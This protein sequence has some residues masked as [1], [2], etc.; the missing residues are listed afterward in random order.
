MRP[1]LTVLFAD[2]DLL[3]V[4]KPA[5]LLSVPGRGPDKQDCAVSRA[6][7]RFGEI[8]VVHRLD[9]A[10][11]G[12][13]LFARSA[14]AQR[15]LNACF[16]SGQVQK[17]YVAVLSA[18]PHV[19]A[20]CDAPCDAP[21]AWNRIDLP[22]IADWPNRPRQMVDYTL[23]K[24]STTL[25]RAMAPAPQSGASTAG[26]NA[27]ATPVRPAGARVLVM[28][29]TGRTHQIRVH[30][31]ALGCPILGDRLY[32]PEIAPLTPRLLL[33]ATALEFPHPVSGSTIRIESAPPF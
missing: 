31:W 6:Q 33:H 14:D 30:F 7:L 10:T 17:T 11:S 32:A 1:P 8:H 20:P 27:A 16:A 29:L 3:A 15:R 12:I 28:P 19:D 18:S 25:W 9:M 13:L 2:Q 26:T 4:E 22:L 23:G 21:D 5:D 24:P